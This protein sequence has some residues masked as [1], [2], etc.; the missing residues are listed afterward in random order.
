MLQDTDLKTLISSFDI[1]EPSEQLFFRVRA[2]IEKQRLASIQKQAWV[3]GTLF[4]G[5]GVA[6]VF[7]FSAMTV[8]FSQSGFL[9]FVSVFISDATVAMVARESFVFALLESFPVMSTIVTCVAVFALLQS[10]RSFAFTLNTLSNF[11]DK[12][13]R[14]ETQ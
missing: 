3:I 13:T 2:A 9:E 7:A 8:D 1:P 5:S 12:M 10:L 11:A 4:F 14:Y 6:V